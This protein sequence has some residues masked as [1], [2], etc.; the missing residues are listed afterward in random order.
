[1]VH[2]A[3]TDMSL[4]WLLGP[5]LRA[6]QAAGYEVVGMS[7]AG[8][9]V[10]ALANDGIRHVPVE[11]L[12]RA[13]GIVADLR[14]FQE[15]LRLL[16]SEQPDVLHTH[17]PKPGILGRIA[18]RMARVPVIV[19]TQ[20][21][22]YAQPTD[23]RRRRWP[24][25][26]A[27]RLAAACSHAE[28][29]QNPE[30]ARTLVDTLKVPQR[31]VTVLG[32]GIDLHRFNGSRAQRDAL[33]TAWGVAED[34]VVVGLV[35]RLVLEKGLHELFAAAHALRAAN[36]PVRLV[37]VGPNDPD[38]PDG[39]TAAMV[40]RA[41][42]DGVVFVGARTDMPDCYAAMDIFATASHR[43][44]FPRAA[45]EASASGLPVIATDIRGCRQVVEHGVT[46]LLIPVRNPVALTAAI[47]SLAADPDRRAAMGAAAT[48]KAAADFDQRRVI[49]IT[50]QTYER[51]LTERGYRVSPEN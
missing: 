40:E 49:D 5:Q 11:N 21:G 1:V 37:A 29:V 45:M 31:R 20:H 25:Y 33:R 44:G 18:G 38:K 2:L 46:G 51:L 22:L 6:F 15:L 3:T 10:A 28:L 50:L 48:L 41:T 24:V 30:D 39:V 8:P 9:H 47:R 42:G 7:A 43:E 26:A 36:L 14:A 12:T 16:R 35:G 32:N 13:P 4:D 34:E 17:N 27:E 23:R 19:N